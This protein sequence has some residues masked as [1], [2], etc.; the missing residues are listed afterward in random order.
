[1]PNL[2]SLIV[3]Y[4]KWA[5]GQLLEEYSKKSDYGP[6]AVRAMEHV[7]EKRGLLD[8]IKLGGLESMLQQEQEEAKVA[9]QAWVE[10]RDV[11]VFVDGDLPPDN[12][13]VFVNAMIGDKTKQRLGGRGKLKFYQEGTEVKMSVECGSFSH[14]QSAPFKCNFYATKTVER[15]NWFKTSEWYTLYVQIELSNGD[16]MTIQEDQRSFKRLP[17]GWEQLDYNSKI[18]ESKYRFDYTDYEVRLVT[19]KKLLDNNR[20]F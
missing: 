10:D 7:L 18:L 17:E 19:L 6:E 14:L 20:K 2:E 3:L 1:M 11:R 12:N 8:K 5:D 4:S 13:G 16:W 15:T 9:E